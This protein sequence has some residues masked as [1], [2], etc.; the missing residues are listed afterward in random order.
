MAAWRGRRALTWITGAVAFLVSIG[1]AFTGY[2][3]QQNLDSQWI[4]GAGEGRAERGRDRR[5]VQRPEL[6]A[7]AA[8]AR[9]AAS[10][11]RRVLIGA[12]HPAGPPSWRRASARPPVAG[13]VSRR[14]RRRRD[15]A[16]DRPS[17]P[18]P[19]AT[20]QRSVPRRYDLV[21]EA[22]FAHRC[23]RGA[24]GRPGR[25]LLLP[26]RKPVTLQR[27]RRPAPNDFVAT[28]VVRTGRRQRHRHLRAPYNHVAG[29]GQNHRPAAAR[30]GW[31]AS[32]SRSTPPRT[33]SSARSR[34]VPT[35]RPC[36]GAARATS[37]AA[38]TSRPPGPANSPT[39]WPRRP[40]A[41]R[42]RSR[43]ATTDRCRRCGRAAAPIAQSGGLDGALTRAGSF[44]QSDFT[45]PL[46]FL[47]DGSYLE[48]QARA[49]APGRRPVGMMNETGQLSRSGLALALH[50]L[51]PD[52][53]VLHVGQRGRARLGADGF[54][55]A[56][57]GAASRSSRECDRSR[58][59]SRCTGSSGGTTTAAGAHPAVTG[60]G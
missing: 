26:G 56:P 27:G 44:Y 8:V 49:A 35:T 14:R 10:A 28:A 32:G 18:A 38:P 7:D 57:A 33:S 9:P 3:S 46:L 2:L 39:R 21:K 13:H 58:G 20:G 41:T 60:R 34:S 48:D 47:A 51:V 24:H 59:S 19:P 55:H 42:R 15:R 30:S 43:R 23:G 53:A 5:L 17:R 54:A 16:P 11:G 22:V 12:A 40:T 31:A 50:V 37:A 4:A 36:R 52:Q 6:R 45:K 1:T 29:A 25:R